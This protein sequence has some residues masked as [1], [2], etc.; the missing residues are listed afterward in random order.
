M[1]SPSSPVNLIKGYTTLEKP[2][3]VESLHK[4]FS[5][6]V[7]MMSAADKMFIP[8]RSAILELYR[9]EEV[10]L[11]YAVF[12][13][14]RPLYKRDFVYM[15]YDGYTEYKGEKIGV[16]L[17]FSL[18]DLVKDVKGCVCGHIEG[19]CVCAVYTYILRSYEAHL[20]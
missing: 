9:H 16:S 20:W 2:R 14:P 3:T 1:K 13:L 11:C 6:F 19:L 10:Y 15:G 5:N 8:S 12:T 18:P 4:Y 17:G 7:T